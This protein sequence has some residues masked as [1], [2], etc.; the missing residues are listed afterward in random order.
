MTVIFWMTEGFTAG[1]AT[2]SGLMVGVGVGAVAQLT[3]NSNKI[4]NANDLIT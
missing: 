1:V 3:I 2:G 4:T